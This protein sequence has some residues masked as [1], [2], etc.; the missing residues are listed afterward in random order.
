MKQV[1]VFILLL[2]SVGLFSQKNPSYD[3][4]YI[5]NR[6]DVGGDI[7]YKGTT[8]AVSSVTG[9]VAVADTT[10]LAPGNYIPRK[11]LNTALALK[12]NLAD[13]WTNVDTAEGHLNMNGN[14]ILDVYAITVDN[15]IV[16]GIVA[17]AG[18]DS[19]TITNEGATIDWAL[20]NIWDLTLNDTVAVVF[21][22]PTY[23]SELTLKIVHDT[24]TVVYPITW[25]SNVKWT[26][27]TQVNTT[28]AN[29]A[30]DIIKFLF[31]ANANKYYEIS[32]SLDIK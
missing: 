2:I 14:N 9:K 19:E 31:D 23:T 17:N 15:I 29:A 20:N 7:T 10:G 5:S 18:M 26:G 16:D 27:G 11:Q 12:G 6:L 21:S 1:L 4:V 32:N 28:D 30:V 24:T 13:A 25:D 22:T 8:I 3:N